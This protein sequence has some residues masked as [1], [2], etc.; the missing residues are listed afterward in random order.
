MKGKPEVT[1]AENR[2]V[3]YCPP[4]SAGTGVNAVLVNPLRGHLAFVIEDIRQI[5]GQQKTLT[6]ADK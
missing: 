3:V 6:W 1:I 5:A 2:A 4:Y